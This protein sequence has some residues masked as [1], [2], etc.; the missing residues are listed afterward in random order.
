MSRQ[1]RRSAPVKVPKVQIQEPGE[2]SPLGKSGQRSLLLISRRIW[3][4]IYFQS[5]S[6]SK[7]TKKSPVTLYVEAKCTEELGI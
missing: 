6:S 7:S 5:L 4:E 3:Y 2:H 1:L